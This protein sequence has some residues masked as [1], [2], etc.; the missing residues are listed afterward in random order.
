MGR[1]A[2]GRTEAQVIGTSPIERTSLEREEEL[3]TINMG[4][5][6]PGDPRGA[7]A[8]GLA[9]GRGRPRPEA[10]DGLRPHRDR[11]VGGDEE[12]LEGDPVPGADGLPLLLLQHGGVLRRRRAA[13]R[14]RDPAAGRVSADHPHGAEPD[15][16]ASG[17]ARDD[18]AGP[19]RDLDVLVLLPRARHDPRPVRD[20]V[21]PADAHALLPGRRRDRGHPGRLR[22]QGARVLRPDAGADRPVRGAARPERDLPAADQE[23]GRRL[24]ASGCSSSA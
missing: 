6:P 20:V 18:G 3:F 23:H 7:A 4:P 14:A 15:P 13:A 9:R 21:G 19:R 2:I 17:R 24:A 22:A 16:L 8:A 10:G 12:L 1:D 5:A 11:E